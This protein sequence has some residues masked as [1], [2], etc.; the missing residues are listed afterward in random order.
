[1]MSRLHSGWLDL[2]IFFAQTA[3]AVG[4]VFGVNIAV[5]FVEPD[6]F[7]DTAPLHFILHVFAHQFVRQ[8]ENFVRRN[9][10]NDVVHVG[11][12]DADV[13]LGFDFGRGVDVADKGEA[14]VFFFQA[15]HV[16]TRDAVSQRASAE[17]ARD[18]HFF[19]RVERLGGF[20]HEFHG[21]ENDDIGIG[22]FG[23]FAELVGIAGE[24]A[25]TVNDF[26]VHVRVH[27]NNGVFFFLQP[28]DFIDQRRHLF[29]A[30]FRVRAGCS[31]FHILQLIVQFFCCCHLI[32]SKS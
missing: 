22:R 5:A 21:N 4:V 27:Q 10:L 28:V 12:G 16:G 6:F 18:A 3:D 23:I 13:A 11:A 14:G 8:E 32:F 24:I 19:G 20:G 30:L 25:D 26:G 9:A 7:F 15:A 2:G 1:M 17:A 29:A 31:G